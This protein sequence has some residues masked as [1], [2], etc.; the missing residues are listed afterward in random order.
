MENVKQEIQDMD[1]GH[2]ICSAVLSVAQCTRWRC[3]R[4]GQDMSLSLSFFCN[5][6]Q[7]PMLG[8]GSN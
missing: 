1:G 3:L 7:E 5:T 8:A 4:V 6:G 2:I